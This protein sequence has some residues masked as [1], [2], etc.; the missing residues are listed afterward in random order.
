MRS[1]Q[2]LLCRQTAN[3]GSFRFVHRELWGRFRARAVWWGVRRPFLVVAQ[4]PCGIGSH[5]IRVTAYRLALAGLG[6]GQVFVP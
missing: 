2:S 1:P 4:A 6:A 5:D 3:S